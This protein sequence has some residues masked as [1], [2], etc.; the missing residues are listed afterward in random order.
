MARNPI[1]QLFLVTIIIQ[2]ALNMP[3]AHEDS[4]NEDAEAILQIDPVEIAEVHIDNTTLNSE[5]H[6]DLEKR[7]L[8]SNERSNEH[9]EHD[10]HKRSHEENPEDHHHA[11]KR[12]ADPDPD[13]HHPQP[14][15]HSA[16]LRRSHTVD[17]E[18]KDHH[19]EKRNPTPDPKRGQNYHDVEQSFQDF[20]RERRSAEHH[21]EEQEHENPDEWLD[22]IENEEPEEIRDRRSTSESST[23]KELPFASDFESPADSVAI[24]VKRVSRAGSSH[25]GRVMNKN[26][27]GNSRAGQTEDAQPTPE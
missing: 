6:H 25:R 22:S 15:P 20:L 14:T 16:R 9:M 21:H 18:H 17:D 8:D 12:T 3:I 1:I 7:R 2:R 11:K 26:R 27:G 19:L 23:E 13:H 4:P 10:L 24:R 5:E